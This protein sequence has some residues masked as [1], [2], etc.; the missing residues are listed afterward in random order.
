MIVQHQ[1]TLMWRQID[2]QPTVRIAME[3]ALV[4]LNNSEKSSIG[5][6]NQKLVESLQQNVPLQT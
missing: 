4:D 3:S 1:L 2:T 5:L 6:A